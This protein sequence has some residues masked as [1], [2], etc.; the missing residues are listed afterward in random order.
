MLHIK[1][2]ST[3]T[4]PQM[5]K[6][7]VWPKAKLS[8][9]FAMLLADELKTHFKG[10]F[11]VE[12]K[13]LFHNDKPLFDIDSDKDSVKSIVGKVFLEK[14]KKHINTITETL[15]DYIDEYAKEEKK[16]ILFAWKKV[17]DMIQGKSVPTAQKKKYMDTVYYA[18]VGYVEDALGKKGGKY[19]DTAWDT[20][21][22]HLMGHDKVSESRK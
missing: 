12:G 22:N 7:S 15:N 3:Y 2:F 8:D 14:N 11:Y 10:I 4:K 6:E 21:K 5:V 18:L 1:N 17:K 20:V 13:K 9:K 19:I 16:D